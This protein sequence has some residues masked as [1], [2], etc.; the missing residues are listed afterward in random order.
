[1]LIISNLYC[2]FCPVCIWGLHAAMALH[3]AFQSPQQRIKGVKLKDIFNL[4]DG[5]EWPFIVITN[6]TYHYHLTNDHQ[7]KIS[8]RWDFLP[9]SN[10][11]FSVENFCFFNFSAIFSACFFWPCPFV[12]PTRIRMTRKAPPRLHSLILM[13][14]RGQWGHEVIV[15]IHSCH[16]LSQFL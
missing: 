16:N 7:R 14:S 13:R 11:G 12:Q 10:F 5:V 3:L 8:W 1:M 15:T 4:I 9:V 2:S 6:D